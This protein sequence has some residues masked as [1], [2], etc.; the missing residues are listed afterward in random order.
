MKFD[1]A[2]PLGTL[3]GRLALSLLA[4]IVLSGCA[5]TS[6]VFGGTSLNATEKMMWCTYP[7]GTPKGMATG[8]AI[9]RRDASV[10]G[11]VAPVVITSVHVLETIGRGPFL[12]GAR[13]TDAA[14]Q[15][16][17]ALIRLQPPR[18]RERFYVRHP[19]H[20][21]A[22]FELPIPPEAM[23]VA[24][25][26]LFLDEKAFPSR[27]DPL[28]AGAEVSFLGFPEVMPGT[29]DA[30][31]I[32]RSGK[33]A[34]YPVGPSNGQGW[35]LIDADVYP[36]DSGAPVFRTGRGGRPILAGVVLR[37]V[38]RDRRAFSHLAIA[39]EAN[40]IH[41]TLDLLAASKAKAR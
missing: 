14:G 13:M 35:F 26:P 10:P 29:S 15:P 19:Q 24:K 40:V 3:F 23:R 27:E 20:D 6:P 4:V 37:R 2:R 18:G 17:L 11:G 12:V 5:G 16:R 33:V 31:P 36:G 21:L 8:F 32:L 39:V 38:G 30:F 28:R 25:L 9:G 1:S 34:S 41:E 7:L 22:A